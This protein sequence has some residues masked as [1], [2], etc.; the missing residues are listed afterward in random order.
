MATAA[1]ENQYLADL[2][3]YIEALAGILP[4]IECE[5][6]PPRL[7]PMRDHPSE[8]NFRYRSPDAGVIQFLLLV[9][10]VSGCHAA[11]QL[12]R[13]G[14]IVEAGVLLRTIDDFVADFLFV[15]DALANEQGPS[16]EQRQYLEHYFLE[17]SDPA[18]QH[19]GRKK[20]V[21]AAKGR[22][23]NSDNPHE[24]VELSGKIGKLYDSY[25]HGEY[26]PV[27]E[28]Y[29]QRKKGGQ[30]EVLGVSSAQAVSVH[31]AALAYHVH[32]AYAVAIQLCIRLGLKAPCEK[33]YIHFRSFKSMNVFEDI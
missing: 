32:Q 11:L 5:V 18:K 13:L 22:R 9:R 29:V 2:S 19:V 28:L 8:Q 4:N 1:Q 20:K 33:L 27:M 3:E 14:H 30:F 6:E 15:G 17:S 26:G 16:T 25:V 21:R 12:L 7:V 24:I 23:L 31:R 10:I